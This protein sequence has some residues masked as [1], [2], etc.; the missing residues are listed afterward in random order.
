MTSWTALSRSTGTAL[1]VV[2]E[3][4][5]PADSWGELTFTELA[6]QARAQAAGLDALG[7]GF[8]ERV[9]VVS[10]N[11]ARLLTS[12]FGGR[13]LRTGTRAGELP[14]GGRRGGLHRRTLGGAIR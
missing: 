11:S 12:F 4:D 8:G 9:A 3:P 13:W 7:V 5:Q 1:A 14:S 2:D 6:G 10:Q